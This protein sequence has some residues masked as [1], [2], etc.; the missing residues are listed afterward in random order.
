M[1]KFMKSVYNKLINSG[2]RE[3]TALSYVN[4]LKSLHNKQPYTSLTFLKKHESMNQK[5]ENIKNPNTKKN[6]L[7]AVVSILK[8]YPSYKKSYEFYGIKQDEIAKIMN[9]D[10]NIG[11]SQNIQQNLIPWVKVIKTRDNLIQ[12]VDEIKNKENMSPKEYHLLFK[13]MVLSLF[14]YIPPRRS[15]DYFLCKL[16]K[17][18]PND[19]NFNYFIIPKKE[20]IFNNYKT[21][22]KYGKQTLNISDEKELTTI[23]EI[24]LRNIL[25]KNPEFFLCEY[26]GSKINHNTIYRV[27][28]NIFGKGVGVTMLRHSYLTSKYGDMRENQK[29]DAEAMAHSVKQQNEVYIN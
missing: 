20:F 9:N 5:L 23:L 24:Y 7:V 16:A 18:E 4:R 17:K 14:T 1:N 3:T 12:Q 15:K 8:M 29:M 19:V 25:K 10:K 11:I 26:D 6:L 2:K 22:D 13:T 27:L 21:Q 28:N